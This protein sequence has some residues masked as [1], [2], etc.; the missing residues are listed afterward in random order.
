[1][2][3][4]PAKAELEKRA[5]GS[6]L[7]RSP[8]KLGPYARCVTEWL[9]QW[10]EQAPER[11]FLAERAPS[12]S[13]RKVT[14]REAYGAVRRIGQALLDRGLGAERPVAILSDNGVD[15]ALL[16]LG[17]MHVGIPAA[18]VSPAYSLMSKD[19][20][21]LK[22]IF[23]LVSPGLVYAADAQKFAPALAAVGATITPVEK[24]LETNPGSTMERAF[25]R[26]GP[27]TTAKILFTSGST[28]LPKGVIN[29]HRMLC[30]NQQQLA[31]AWPLVE[32]KPPVI[33]DWLPWNHTFGGN[34]NFNM[35]LR[36]GGT[37]Y[38]DGGKPVPGLVETTAR[39]LKEVPLTMYFNVPRGY[40][41]LLP[42]LEKDAE[43]RANFFRELEVLFYAAA[44]LPLN[45]WQ[46]IKKLAE[47]ENASR[48]AMLSAWGSTE[49][50]PLATSVHFIMERPGVIGLPVAGCE[51]KLV[52]S[53][54]KLEVRV[55]GTNVTPGYY[56]R[57][58]LT[59][60]AFDEEGFYRIG[61]A[62]KFADPA[63]P[64]K[65]IVF[66]GRVA[67]DFKLSTGTWVNVGAVR[68]RLIATADPII[69]DAVITGHDR[70]VV[71]ALVFL[72]PAAKDLSPDELRSRLSA[73]LKKLAQEGGSSTHPV[74]VLVM[75]EP[76]SIDANEITDKGYMNQR[77]VLERRAALVEK[78]YGADPDIITA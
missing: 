55:R 75:S 48:L 56:K 36:N 67:E 58:D 27:D 74:R 13:W 78:L 77:A 62:V 73:A 49:T 50:S 41:L 68:I 31:Q 44:A 7:L 21:K 40:D 52:P 3:L 2:R 25:L 54:G 53:A 4:A 28:G 32:A 70:D 12:G 69:Q 64:A 15:H 72:S 8:Q 6:M 35:V 14:Y 66:D 10:S 71:G 47:A 61:D 22:Y 37:L 30:A 65:G 26:V 46:R 60:I 20:G 19:F 63:D 24:L 29:T 33:V 1:M 76:P 11:V 18:P 51:L 16:A 39:N 42:F 59:K 43:L 9:V 45:L 34:H 38:I 57:P 23:E 17:A 5:D